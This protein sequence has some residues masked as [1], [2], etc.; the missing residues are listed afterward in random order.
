[1]PKQK[2]TKKEKRIFWS[3][4]LTGIVGGFIGSLLIGYLFRLSDDIINHKNGLV[5]ILGVILF[6]SIFF[7][8]LFFINKQIKLNK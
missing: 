1:M 5:D 6:T 8:I 3:G 7:A 2:V 4:A